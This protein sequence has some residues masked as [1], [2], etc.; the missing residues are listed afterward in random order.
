MRTGLKDLVNVETTTVLYGFYMVFIWFL[1]GFYGFSMV[2]DMVI[3]GLLWFTMDY[4]GFT[5]V[6]YG[7]IWFINVLY[8]F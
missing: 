1:Y 8:I 5:I 2:L 4:Y 3:Y 6:C 7:F